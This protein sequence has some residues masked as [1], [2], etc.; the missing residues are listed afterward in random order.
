MAKGGKSV[1][2]PPIRRKAPAERKRVPARLDIQ[3]EIA[4]LRRE[5]AETLDRQKQR[6]RFSRSSAT[7]PA[8]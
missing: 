6:Q 8:N 3:E 1:R 4:V 2:K 5:L 7:G